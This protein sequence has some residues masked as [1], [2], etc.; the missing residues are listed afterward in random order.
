MFYLYWPKI[1]GFR[2]HYLQQESRWPKKE[3]DNF[4]MCRKISRLLAYLFQILPLLS[5]SVAALLV[6]LYAK[7]LFILLDFALSDKV[8]RIGIGTSRHSVIRA[9]FWDCFRKFLCVLD[10]KST[11]CLSSIGVGSVQLLTL[12]IRIYFS[13]IWL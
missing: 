4:V 3:K 5:K 11:Y 12:S 7:A 1:S 13:I 10:K 8:T 6:D 9:R 2:P